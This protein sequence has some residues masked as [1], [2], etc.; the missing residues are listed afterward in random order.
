MVRSKFASSVLLSSLLLFPA[1]LFAGAWYDSLQ[2][3][4]ININGNTI[5]S[6]DSNGNIILSPNGG[7]GVKLP[8]Q[9][10]GRV[11]VTDGTNTLVADQ[12]ITTAELFLL[13]G[14]TT[15][16]LTSDAT[17]TLTNKTISASSNTITNLVDANFSAS[18]AVAYDKLANLTNSRALV[19]NGTGDVSVATT[20][21]TEIGYVNGVTSAIQT[22]LDARQSR[23]TLTTKGDIYA[24]T[25]SATVARLPVGSN[26]FVLTADSAEATGLKWA[27]QGTGPS[28]GLYC[29]INW[30]YAS[31]AFWSTSSSTFALPAADTDYPT[32]TV[33]TST[34]G[35]AA[36]I[37]CSAPGTK[38]AQLVTTSLPA[39]EYQVVFESGGSSDTTVRCYG[40]VTDGTTTGKAQT[41]GIGTS[42]Q[43]P[44]T[45][46]LD[47]VYGS[48]QSP[49]FSF[50]MASNAGGA[51]SILNGYDTGKS[52]ST[53][54]L[55]RI[56]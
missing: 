51:C 24:A 17:A 55:Y 1:I 54:Y 19:S 5:S 39:G 42:T 35:T 53:I 38:V 14:L 12:D 32:P 40:R 18:A 13:N 34:I 50:H 28:L 33:T 8:Q 23:S 6:T 27:A 30:G 49:T 52:E 37:T 9:P 36:G 2:V 44:I 43:I 41:F 29:S 47:V 11:M 21:S 16:P 31:N 3:D 22:Q 56:R 10:T 7:G 48:T 25:A 15:A 4:N 20:T 45:P 26:T 46:K